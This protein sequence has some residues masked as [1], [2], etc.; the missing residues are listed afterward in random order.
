MS[1]CLAA[2]SVLCVN[3]R[4]I[5]KSVVLSTRAVREFLHAAFLRPRDTGCDL[6]AFA[7][8]VGA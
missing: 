2:R 7:A 8:Q 3:F 4:H 1:D 6:G 5:S